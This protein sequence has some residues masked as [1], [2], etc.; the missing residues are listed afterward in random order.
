M[1]MS[2]KTAQK[3]KQKKREQ[4]QAW[5]VPFVYVGA[6]FPVWLCR[7][8]SRTAPPP[9]LARDCLI[10]I[11]LDI[12]LRLF[13]RPGRDEDI[14]GERRCRRRCFLLQRLDDT[15]QPGNPFFLA[16]DCLLQFR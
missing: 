6:G 2:L 16:F 13:Q 4:P 15:F 12:A 5:S 9:Q 7:R 8:V 11:A 3:S 14:D 10:Q 1:V